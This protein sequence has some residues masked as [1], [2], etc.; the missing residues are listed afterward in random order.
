[1]ERRLELQVG[2]QFC[3]SLKILSLGG[4]QFFRVIHVLFIRYH[5]VVFRHLVLLFC[6]PQ[7]GVYCLAIAK[8]NYRRC[9]ALVG[10]V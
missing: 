10:S 4:K 2:Q 7:D 5:L 9:G 6:Q 1:M 3:F 8:Y